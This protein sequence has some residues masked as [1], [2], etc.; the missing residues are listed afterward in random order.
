MP[1]LVGIGGNAIPTRARP[2]V[3]ISIVVDRGGGSLNQGPRPDGVVGV[4]GGRKLM[5]AWTK[6]GQN[7]RP[8]IAK[9]GI[10]L[11]K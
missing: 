9:L 3:E 8:R 7:V 1:E 4:V 6:S 2:L 5:R 10:F 11:E